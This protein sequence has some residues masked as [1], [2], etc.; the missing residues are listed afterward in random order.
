M[1]QR[2]A[3]AVLALASAATVALVIALKPN[4][5]GAAL[6]IGTWLLLPYVLVGLAL[7]YVARSPKTLRTYA[8]MALAIPL[9]GLA[10]LVYVIYLRPDAQGGIAVMFT[11]VYQLLAAVV[12]LAVCDR[13]FSN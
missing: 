7:R 11:P 4:T 12:L 3:Y 8:T 5:T 10:F 6:A 9:G 13:A 1:L 2:A